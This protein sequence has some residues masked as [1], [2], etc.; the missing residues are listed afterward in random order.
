MGQMD[1]DLAVEEREGFE[2][3]ERSEE[4]MPR[5][6]SANRENRWNGPGVLGVVGTIDLF[7]WNSLRLMEDQFRVIGRGWIVKD[8]E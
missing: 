8:F 6:V 4:H 1:L 3:R 2:Q 7:S 5:T